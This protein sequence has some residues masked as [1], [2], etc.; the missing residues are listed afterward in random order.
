MKLK[1]TNSFAVECTESSQTVWKPVSCFKEDSHAVKQKEIRWLAS[2]LFTLYNAVYRSWL[3]TTVLLPFSCGY[4]PNEF[5]LITIPI[6]PTKS[7]CNRHN[8]RSQVTTLGCVPVT[9]TDGVL[10][11]FEPELDWSTFSVPLPEKDIPH[12]H[13]MLAAVTDKSYNAMLVRKWSEHAQQVLIKRTKR[14]CDHLSW[15]LHL[16]SAIIFSLTCAYSLT[17]V[18]QGSFHKLHMA[19]NFNFPLL[20]DFRRGSQSWLDFPTQVP[21]IAENLWLQTPNPVVPTSSTWQQPQCRTAIIRANWEPRVC[22]NE[23]ERSIIGVEHNLLTSHC[24]ADDLSKWFPIGSSDQYQAIAGVG[25]C[26]EGKVNESYMWLWSVDEDNYEENIPLITCVWQQDRMACTTQHLS[27][28]SF[29]GANLGESGAFDAF[30]T[31]MAILAARL[32][33]PGVPPD[34][35]AGLDILLGRFMECMPGESLFYFAFTWIFVVA[36]TWSLYLMTW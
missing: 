35:L 19:P 21:T 34:K 7:I 9:V 25:V 23:M 5:H 20:Q 6:P 29:F 11:P 16:Y 31:L 26:S 14:C 36:C 2:T 8:P 33:H 12:M 1:L 27:Y 24:A 22:P 30:E 32:R 4:L 18:V 13:L 28:T 3:C 17:F 10:Q 15:G